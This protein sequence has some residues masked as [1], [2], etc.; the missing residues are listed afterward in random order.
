MRAGVVVY[1]HVG[2]WHIASENLLLVVVCDECGGFFT[3]SVNLMICTST[4]SNLE[5]KLVMRINVEAERQHH[6]DVRPWAVCT[7]EPRPFP[8]DKIVK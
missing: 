1:V 8:C 6:R 7:L 5:S 4:A 3:S 2:K